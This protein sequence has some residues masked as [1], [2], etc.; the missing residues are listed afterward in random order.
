MRRTTRKA[1]INLGL[2]ATVLL[3][4]VY[5]NGP[6]SKTKTFAWN[7]IRY[8]PTSATLPKSR[9]ICHGVSGSSKPV[10][11]VS[12]VEAD[13]DAKWLDPLAK[14]YH[15]C[16]YTVD[17][18][19]SDSKYLQVPA[20]RGHEGMAY[21]TFIIDN[22]DHIPAAGAVFVH[23][24]RFQWHNDEPQYDNV[25]LLSA[26]NVSRALEPSGYHNLRCDWS[27]STCPS[28]VPPQGSFETSSQAKLVPWD[29][30]AASDAGLP[31]ALA[32]I[33]GGNDISTVQP[34]ASDAV[35][36]QCCAQFVVSRKSILRH[37]RE[38]YVALRQWLL[39]DNRGD[40]VVGRI[41]SY[42][43]HILFIDQGGLGSEGINLNKLN[44]RACP[45]AQEC[46]CRL[47]GRCNLE[48]CTSGSCNGQYELPTDLKLP[49]DWAQTHGQMS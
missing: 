38:E 17:A 28:S 2:F 30:R 13:G 12:R 27:L 11:V 10:L 20:N 42:V 33:F 21:L 16:V 23:G 46:Y 49:K 44:Q 40:L 37:S 26:L 15:F 22:Y 5:L 39:E 3:F 1:L 35:R 29:D 18:P 19:D 9:G 4:I 48:G 7:E 41:L 24:A 31:K 34:S 32:A 43:W 14:L 6:Q 8:K 47:Y 45:S 25:A 36:S